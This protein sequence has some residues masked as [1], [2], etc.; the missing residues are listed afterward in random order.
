[1]WVLFIFG[2]RV[3]DIYLAIIKHGKYNLIKLPENKSDIEKLID[4][5]EPEDIHLDYKD[6][7]AL[8]D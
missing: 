4:R 3:G 5:N 1:M 7:R 2:D 6:G 8:H